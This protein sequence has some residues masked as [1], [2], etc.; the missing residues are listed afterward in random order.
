MSLTKA[1]IIK[2]RK[3]EKKTMAYEL[4]EQT[5]IPN[6]TM[7][8]YIDG[9]GNFRG[10]RITPN[11]GYAMHDN[12][13]DYVAEEPLLDEYGNPMFDE[14][15]NPLTVEVVKLGYKTAVGS[16]SATYDF[17]PTQM[18]DENGVTVTAYGSRQFFCKLISEVGEGAE[19][20]GVGNDH[21][22]V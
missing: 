20:F 21:E 3:R 5:L 10:Y 6:T 22:T 7:Q 1:G 16:V 15:G 14:Y 19:I 11:T 9:N 8:R 13:Y 12:G 17:T 18:Q 2:Q 4:M